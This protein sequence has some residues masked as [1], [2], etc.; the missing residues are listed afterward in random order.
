MELAEY[1]TSIMHRHLHS[2]AL[3]ST[4]MRAFIDVLA[5][6]RRQFDRANIQFWLDFRSGIFASRMW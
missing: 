4:V 3:S 1:M 5:D 6:C 2:I